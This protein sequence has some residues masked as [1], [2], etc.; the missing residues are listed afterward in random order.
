MVKQKDPETNQKSLLFEIEFPEITFKTKPKYRLMSAFEQR[1]E[2]PD[3]KYQY[4]LVAAEPYETVGFK[5][6][7]IEID[8][9]EGKYFEAWDKEQKRYTLQLSFADQQLLNRATKTAAAA[10]VNEND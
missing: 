3:H 4:L 10:A 6:P 8:F 5:I 2:K 7:N 1:V 9:S